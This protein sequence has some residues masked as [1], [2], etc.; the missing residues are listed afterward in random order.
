MEH[1]L[2]AP[3]RELVPGEIVLHPLRIRVG[4]MS[5]LTIGERQVGLRLVRDH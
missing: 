5:A 4:A 1:L 2:V 3:Q